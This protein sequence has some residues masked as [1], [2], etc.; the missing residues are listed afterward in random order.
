M[1][2]RNAMQFQPTKLET[3]EVLYCQG[4]TIC[5]RSSTVVLYSSQRWL[6]VMTDVTS[7]KKS[8]F[9]WRGPKMM[10]LDV[11]FLYGHS[12]PT[13]AILFQGDNGSFGVK[14]YEVIDNNF[15]LKGWQLP[16]NVVEPTLL[17]PVHQD[18]YGFLII[19]KE[20]FVYCKEQAT[21]TK[22]MGFFNIKAYGRFHTDTRKHSYLLGDHSGHLLMI[23]LPQ[24]THRILGRISIPSSISYLRDTIVFV[25]SCSTDSQLIKINHLAD[26]QVLNTYANLGPISDFCVIN[27]SGGQRKLLMCCGS[28]EESAIELFYTGTGIKPKNFTELPNVRNVWPLKSS[29]LDDNH[30]Y[31]VLQTLQEV[32]FVY[33]IVNDGFVAHNFSGFISGLATLC[34]QN[35]IYKQFI[36]V[37]PKSVRLICSK[38]GLLKHIWTGK[39]DIDCASATVSQILVA[40][41]NYLNY[42]EIRDGDLLLVKEIDLG[43]TA[44]CLDI[45]YLGE[46]RHSSK[47]AAVATWSENKARIFS[48]PNL[49]LLAEEQLSCLP[50]CIILC[51]FGMEP[52]L[53][54]GLGD[55]SLFSFKWKE[56]SFQLEDKTSVS[57]GR[58][59][60]T[61]RKFSS[62]GEDY[63]FF[64]T[65]TM[66][67]IIFYKNDKLQHETLNLMNIFD[68]CPFQCDYVKDGVVATGNDGFVFCTLGDIAESGKTV[69]ASCVRR[70]C[71]QEETQ[72]YAIIVEE[73]EQTKR[74]RILLLDDQL[75]TSASYKLDEHEIGL[76]IISSRFANDNRF[77][78]CVGTSF[79]VPGED[80]PI[81]GRILVLLVINGKL[82][83]VTEFPTDG[84]VHYLKNLHGGLLVNISH[85]TPRFFE[86]MQTVRELNENPDVVEPEGV[87]ERFSSMCSLS[88][89]VKYKLEDIVIAPENRNNHTAILM[90]ENEV[91]F[92]S[93][94]KY[95]IMSYNGLDNMVGQWYS[96]EFITQIKSGTLSRLADEDYAQVPSVL[97]STTTS[98]MRVIVSLPDGVYSYLQ[99]LEKKMRAARKKW[100]HFVEL[101]GHRC[102][103]LEN[104]RDRKFI[105]GD[106][107]ESYMTL[108]EEL[109]WE[110]ANDM[111]IDVPTLI[112]ILDYLALFH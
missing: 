71:H 63:V 40:T 84:A 35:A 36:Q 19:G 97:F 3:G 54:C 49:T 69:I 37:T 98:A 26:L 86:W 105:D 112:K 60:L 101:S 65:P 99:N 8:S 50:R 79:S 78:Y 87:E 77:Y 42:F 103:E 75:N 53:L 61:L 38:T 67:S 20:L 74:H 29:I 108:S 80:A 94:A 83:R 110:I 102:I 14:V 104:A 59:C 107:L 62:D 106:F 45:S 9:L 95:I 68:A 89:K 72:S 7:Y 24:L 32:I 85:T 41:G 13:M 21:K 76:S 16:D 11:K 56:E 33:T 18:P 81:K 88:Q 96:G 111:G 109:Q 5:P 46:N 39:S 47:L 28:N 73:K 15:N 48:L 57:L 1:N 92:S 90:M 93:N 12:S 43:Y 70:I 52:Y 10:I 22:R 23:E 30:T 51:A 64:S 25:G 34:C 66:P 82:V 44:A 31:L 6:R 91:L 17:I 4:G 58:S 2:Y 27:K 100:D 55:G